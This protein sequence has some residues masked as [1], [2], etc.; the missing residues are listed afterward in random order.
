ML[1]PQNGFER[2]ADNFPSGPWKPLLS[3]KPHASVP[4]ENSLGTFQDEEDNTQYDPTIYFSL[5]LSH[6]A[7]A[8][9]IKGTKKRKTTPSDKRRML[10]RLGSTRDTN[11]N[12]RYKHPYETEISNLKYPDSL[13]EKRDPIPYLPVEKSAAIWVDTFE[14]VLDMLEDLK[15]APEIAIDLE[16]H[17]FR[18]Y[19]GLLSLM[20]VST[21]D[22]DWVIDTLKPWRHRLEV[23]NEVFA[24]PTKVKV[25]TDFLIYRRL[26]D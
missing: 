4:L 1:K 22:K 26:L 15:Q 14:G 13:Y 10:Q 2:K 7:K 6:L 3:T 23:L 16:H 9:A 20:Q 5:I 19:N 24:D 25:R 8:S 12:F 17:D 18:T 21:R 11:G